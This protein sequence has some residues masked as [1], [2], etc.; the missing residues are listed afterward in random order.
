MDTISRT[1]WPPK[2][3]WNG[4]RKRSSL[5]VWDFREN[6][7]KLTSLQETNI[8]WY[9]VVA[10]K[11]FF[12]AFNEFQ[13]SWSYCLRTTAIVYTCLLGYSLYLDV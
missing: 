4:N 10:S 8:Q 11:V 6:V 1:G 9:I 7:K 12:I 3:I 13:V 5:T 2:N